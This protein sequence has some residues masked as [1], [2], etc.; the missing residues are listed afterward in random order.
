MHTAAEHRQREDVYLP[1][2]LVHHS[3]CGADPACYIQTSNNLHA[4]D[5]AASPARSLPH[6]RHGDRQARLPPHRHRRLVAAVHAGAEH[7][8]AHIQRADLGASEAYGR[9]AGPRVTAAAQRRRAR[10]LT[11]HHITLLWITTSLEGWT[12]SLYLVS[13]VC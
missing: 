10:R 4:V 11:H 7:G 9:E 12:N 5:P 8:P 3:G 2:V 13:K 6:H 1:V